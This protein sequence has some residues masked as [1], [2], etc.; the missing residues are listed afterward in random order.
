MN[1]D[2]D[3]ILIG[4]D[5]SEFNFFSISIATR[6]VLEKNAQ[7][8]AV[9]SDHQFLKTPNNLISGPYALSTP[10]QHA[11]SIN[12]S[13]LGKPNI[14]SLNL[15][16]DFQKAIK[17][18]E[19]IWVIGDGI[20]TDL[21]LASSLNAKSIIVLTGVAAIDDLNIDILFTGNV[22]YLIYVLIFSN[23]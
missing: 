2:V 18:F 6:Y 9:G 8:F 17:G 21:E 20:E 11:A 3:A 12:Q 19:D 23:N 5:E 15:L 1:N 7:F 14:E 4:A 22:N 10:A 13:I 16:D